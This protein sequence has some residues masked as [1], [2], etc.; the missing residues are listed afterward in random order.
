MQL[1]KKRRSRAGG[2]GEKGDLRKV[3]GVEELELLKESYPLL[4]F[5]RN[6]WK[7]LRETGLVF[8]HP[9][10]FHK[11]RRG[12]EFFHLVRCKL[13]SNVSPPSF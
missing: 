12:C 2:I 10:G 8:L 7:Q 13:F 4:R 9:F 3:R 1:W 6:V 11:V 5:N